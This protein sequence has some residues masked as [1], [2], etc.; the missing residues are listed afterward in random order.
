MSEGISLSF[1]E[2]GDAEIS[3]PVQGSMCF[4]GVVCKHSYFCKQGMWCGFGDKPMT[5]YDEKCPAGFWVKL[6]VPIGHQ[7]ILTK[8]NILLDNNH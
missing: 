7:N 6:A 1:D 4:G 2:N 8:S 3:D 5:D